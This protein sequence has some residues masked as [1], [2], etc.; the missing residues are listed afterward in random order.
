MGERN[1]L[2]QQDSF[3]LHGMKD[4]RIGNWHYRD[5]FLLP[6]EDFVLKTI[7]SQGCPRG[8]EML[9]ELKRKVIRNY[10]KQESFN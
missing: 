2:C 3:P 7:S 8:Q 9:L 1:K 5:S 4:L 6:L 10:S